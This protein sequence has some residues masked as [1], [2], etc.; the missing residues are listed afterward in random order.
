MVPEPICRSTVAHKTVR[1]NIPRRSSPAALTG[2][3]PHLDAAGEGRQFQTKWRET[4]EQ[5]KFDR[6]TGRLALTKNH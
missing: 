5:Q 3:G 1:R 6:T 4:S 2:R